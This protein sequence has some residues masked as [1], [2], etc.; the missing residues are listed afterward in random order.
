MLHTYSGDPLHPLSSNPLFLLPLLSAFSPP[1]LPYA[2]VHHREAPLSQLRA[3]TSKPTSTII[4]HQPIRQQ[5]HG[6]KHHNNL[7]ANVN[8]L[9]SGL[10]ARLGPH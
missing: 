9:C 3:V 6:D 2:L 5:Q 8:R 1:H 4:G 7:S 10:Q